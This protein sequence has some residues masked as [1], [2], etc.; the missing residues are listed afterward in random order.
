MWLTQNAVCS[1]NLKGK[2]RKG[3]L[4]DSLNHHWKELVHKQVGD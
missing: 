1:H 3:D 4:R 2:E